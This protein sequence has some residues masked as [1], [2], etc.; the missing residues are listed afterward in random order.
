MQR[1]SG[2][3]MKKIKLEIAYDGTNYCGWQAQTNSI[4]VEEVINKALSDLLQKETNVMG[5]SRTDSGV[6]S[7]G[8]VAVF[9]TD[10][11]IPAEKISHALNQ[12][13]PKD[14]QV[15]SSVEVDL[16]FHPRQA[17]SKKIYQYRILNRS[18][19]LPTERLYSCY[20]YRKL[21]VDAMKAASV[22]LI[23][24]HDYKSFCSIKTQ[25]RDTVRTIYSLDVDK[26]GD[27]IVITVVGNGFLYNMVRIIAGTLIKVG[28]G[29][30]SP[31]KVKDILAA[32]DRSHAGPTAPA[33]GLT[34]MKIDYE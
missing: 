33:H 26:S 9:K 8:N 18:F 31:D 15:Q 30:Y 28:G 20:V 17:K 7:M 16:D 25:A 1:G 14:I 2:Y 4:T 13:L 6:H 27:I 23:G 34:L 10:T 22:H 19:P 3:K 24:S 29:A 5:V 32:C 12:R 21:D 11:I